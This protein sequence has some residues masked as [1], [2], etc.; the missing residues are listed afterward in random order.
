METITKKDLIEA[1]RNE[2]VTTHAEARNAV[3]VVL[4]EI[5]NALKEGKSVTLHGFGTFIV[6]ERAERTGFNPTTMERITIPPCKGVQF[7]PS[8][9]LKEVVNQK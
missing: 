7:K 1:V 2:L 5:T 9:Q 3:E 6:K 8:G 4:S